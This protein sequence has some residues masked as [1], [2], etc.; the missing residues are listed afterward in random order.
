MSNIFKR[1]KLFEVVCLLILLPLIITS[2]NNNDNG[3]EETS[4]AEETEVT[5]ESIL[6]EDLT[7]SNHY[8]ADI[9][10]DIFWEFNEEEDEL[11]MMLESPGSGWLSIGFDASDRMNEAKIIIAGFDEDNNFQLEEHIGTSATSHEP[12]EETYITEST[13][14]R[15]EESSIAEFIIPLDEDSRYNIEQGEAQEVIIAFHSSSDGFMQR[16]SQRDSVEIEF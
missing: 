11:H 15:E 10:L 16:H 1:K 14:E 5:R 4:G 12:I 7:Y 8:S 9:D 13:G 2:C 3:E 6:T